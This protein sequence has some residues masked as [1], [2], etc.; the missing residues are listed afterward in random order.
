M[1]LDTSAWVEFFIGNARGRRV[2][3]VLRKEPCYTCIV[4]IAEA[5]NWALKEKRDPKL[6]LGIIEKLSIVINMDR[7][8]S[9]LAGK[10][11]FNRKQRNKKWGMLD[12]FIL[13]TGLSY[14]LKIL[15]KDS[16]FEDVENSELI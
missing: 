7:D 13:A 14:G 4:S 5:A 6:L 11:N 2:R 12:S 10:L 16:D 15:T 1:L 9:A 8:L 3:E